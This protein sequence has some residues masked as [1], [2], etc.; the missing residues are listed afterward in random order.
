MKHKH[1]YVMSYIYKI[2][3]MLKGLCNMYKEK[4]EILSHSLVLEGRSNLK[5]TGVK[6]IESFDES[7]V[8]LFTSE[9]LL[10]I[11]GSGL[12][13]SK[14]DLDCGNIALDG[15]VFTINYSGG[16]SNKTSF[17]SKIFR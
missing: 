4:V 3:Q 14:I 1:I 12:H 15:E 11:H 8:V 17:F 13:I 6:D 9:G 10:N 2:H 5:I 7:L 16:E